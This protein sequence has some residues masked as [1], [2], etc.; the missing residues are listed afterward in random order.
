MVES[1]DHETILVL[2]VGLPASG[3]TTLAQ[4]I[5]KLISNTKLVSLDEIQLDLIKDEQIDSLEAWH[6]SK[7]GAL[8]E[9]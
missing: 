5:K 2:L 6:R 3:K 4:S 1:K 8:A 7:E 9:V